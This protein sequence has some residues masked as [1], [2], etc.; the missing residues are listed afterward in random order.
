MFF[1]CYVAAVSLEK[2]AWTDMD[3]GLTAASPVG[4]FSSMSNKPTERSAE[5]VPDPP[6]H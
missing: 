3:A 4:L 6:P 1:G 2:V 5:E